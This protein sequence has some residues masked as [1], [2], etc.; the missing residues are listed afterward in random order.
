MDL[1]EI[2][3]RVRRTVAE[4]ADLSMD[5]VTGDTQLIGPVAAIKS[6]ALVEV[7]LDLEEF[8]EDALGAEFD[9]T[10]DAAMSESRSVFRTV[11][12][13]AGHLFDLQR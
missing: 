4:C 13:L 7:L 12:T 5:S 11:D 2:K 3:D 9:W 1:N 8:A 6:R 10:S